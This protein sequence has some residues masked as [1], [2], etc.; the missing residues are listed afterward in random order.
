MS[1]LTLLR[2]M[3]AKEIRSTLRERSQLMGLMLGVALPMI[4]AGLVFYQGVHASRMRA[5]R[6][7]TSSVATG[8]AGRSRGAGAPLA[9]M[10]R[11]IGVPPE[12]M[13][14]AAI[15]LP[16]VLGVFFSIGY[17]MSAVLASFVGEKEGRTLEILLASP[18]SDGKLFFVK[19]VS[20]LLPSACLAYVFAA[21]ASLA[22]VA[23]AP[24][25][26][27]RMAGSALFF[28]LVLGVPVMILPQIW[29]VGLGA[30]ISVKAETMKGAGQVLGAFFMI[31]FFG[32]T[33]GVPLLLQTFPAVRARLIDLGKWWLGLPFME[34]YGLALLLL[35]VPAVVLIGIGRSLFRRDRMLT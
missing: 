2:V 32:L 34:Q 30:A 17:L 24:P 5:A 23:A 1:N 18:I 8:S 3:V 26:L 25:E 19:C 11:M 28:G 4:I 13:R 29:F 31:P 7:P 10:M 6:H 20:V 14:W 15:G 27:L 9:A 21:C 35:S 16:A 22:A 33:Y 12:L